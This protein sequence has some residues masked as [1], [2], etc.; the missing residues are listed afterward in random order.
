MATVSR[1]SDA[2]AAKALGP[3]AILAAAAFLIV[4]SEFLI[5]GLLPA[6]AAD[7]R[8][9]VS[10]AGQLVTL[11]AVAVTVCGPIL[12]VLTAHV[13]RKKLFTAIMLVFAASNALAACAPDLHVLAI[14]RFVPGMA[15]PVFWGTASDTAGQLAG[16]ERAGRAVAQVYLGISAALLFGVPL[17]TLAAGPLGWRG[18]FWI[19]AAAS[20]LMAVLL[21]AYMPAVARPE[22]MRAAEQLR[23]FGHRPFLAN[24]LLSVVLFTGSFTGYTYLA[25]TLGRIAHVPGAYVGWW[26]MGFGAIGLVG[27]WAAGHLVGRSPMRAT[28]L[29][30]TLLAVAM[31][32]AVPAARSPA[33]LAGVLSVWGI[34]YTALFPVSQVRVMKSAT[35]ARALAGTLNVAA[36]NAGTA[37]GAMAGGATIAWYGL[38]RVGYV[39]AAI[40]AASVALAWVIGQLWP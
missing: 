39:G 19:L 31:A 30:A 22:R 17:G 5:V 11:F 7:L 1:S 14:A 29:F 40:T 24:V 6:L 4:T 26:L 9:S 15:L 25:D 28:I 23:I 16:P 2:A 3:I 34:A 20:L 18:S 38:D 37:F 10:L 8:I 33:A 13:D 12:T 36:A 35:V 27:N 21:I 32:A